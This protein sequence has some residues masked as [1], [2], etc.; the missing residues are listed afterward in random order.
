VSCAAPGAVLVR[1][2][3]FLSCN[4]ALYWIALFSTR[5]SRS[6]MLSQGDWRSSFRHCWAIGF[7]LGGRTRYDGVTP[8]WR[9]RDSPCGGHQLNTRAGDVWCSTMQRGTSGGLRPK[10]LI[11]GR[12]LASTRL[13]EPQLAIRNCRIDLLTGT[14][15]RL[16]NQ[17]TS[18]AFLP[19]SSMLSTQGYWQ[20]LGM[21]FQEAM[22]SLPR[23]AACTQLS[24]RCAVGRGRMTRERHDDGFFARSPRAC[25]Y[26]FER[27][28]PYQEEGFASFLAGTIYRHVLCTEF[29]EKCRL[30]FKSTAV[31]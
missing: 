15:S 10:F 25:A 4:R 8:L 14:G 30:C 7:Y 23:A 11:G 2:Y 9:P 13:V 21:Q 31:S 6:G 24:R 5:K 26:A 18:L 12:N 20:S 29:C 27:E 19:F 16:D 22:D 28:C 17:K 3:S 1:R